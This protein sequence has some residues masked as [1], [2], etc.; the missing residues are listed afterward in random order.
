LPGGRN[1]QR[2]CKWSTCTYHNSQGSCILDLAGQGGL[3]QEE[4]ATA[5][6]IPLED[7]Q[8]SE[9]SALRKLRLEMKTRPL[10]REP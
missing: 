8:K 9:A 7:L 5:L 10:P 4:V 2:P 1:A 3:T 6:K